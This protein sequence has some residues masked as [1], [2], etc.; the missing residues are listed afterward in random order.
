MWEIDLIAVVVASFLLAGLVKGLVGLGLPTIALALLATRIDLKDAI[1]L[2]L[3][4]SLATNIWQAV[5]GGALAVL[6]K[7]L[8][9]LLA[10]ACLGIW[11]GAGVLAGLDAVLVSGL[12]GALICAHAAIS[13]TGLQAPAPGARETWLSPLIG[14][15]NGVIT[16]LTGSFIFPSVLYLQALALPRDHLVQAMGITFLVSTLAMAVALSGHALL[17]AEAG[18]LSAVALVPALA[19]M[20]LGQLLRKRLPEARFRKVFFLALAA[21]GAYLTAAAF[22]APHL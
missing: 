5:S 15:V 22:L 3:V 7:R 10:P 9:P 4:P 16:G 2:V 11:I 14:S 17:P 21:L 20:A 12:F 8:W 18:L 13:I 1:P 6:L 19:G